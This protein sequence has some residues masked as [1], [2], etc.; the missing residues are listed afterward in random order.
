[1]DNSVK[2][3]TWLG[4]FENKD[5]RNDYLKSEGYDVEELKNQGAS[6]F[7]KL[8]AD[9]KLKEAKRKRVL[10]NKAKE[11]V[12]SQFPDKSFPNVLSN[13]NIDNLRF[14]Y[15]FS[16]LE[17]ITADDALNMLND[18]QL[19]KIIEKLEQENG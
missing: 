10:F 4:N 16:N 1:M 8:I 17:S 15:H 18:E 5:E 7:K 19:L 6:K 2:I 11:L 14:D 3:L 12:T 9:Q 13:L